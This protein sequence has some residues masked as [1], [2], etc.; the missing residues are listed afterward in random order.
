MSAIKNTSGQSLITKLLSMLF[1]IF[2]IGFA[3]QAAIHM[4]QTH[5]SEKL[6]REIQNAQIQGILGGEIISHIQEVEKSYYALT[7]QLKP[8]TR[9]LIT[10]EVEVHI[11]EINKLINVLEHGGVFTQQLQLNLPDKDNVINTWTYNPTKQ[12][13]Y[14]ILRIDVV[15]KLN[16]ILEQFDKTNALLD[17]AYDMLENN[18]ELFTQQ[19]EKI[20]HDIKRTNPLFIRLLENTNRIHYQQQ[21]YLKQLEE[22]VE[23]Q[24][25]GFKIVQYASIVFLLLLS[26]VLFKV[27]SR[28]IDKMTQ[29]LQVQKDKALAATE[30]KSQFLANMSH[31]I[32]TPLNAITG[33]INLLKQQESEPTKVKYLNTIDNSSQSLLGII[34]DIL[35]FSKIES[36]KLE[37]DLIDFDPHES[38]SSVADLFKAKCS[39]KNILLHVNIDKEMPQSLHSDPL[40]IKQV[41]SN[42]L[43]NAVKFSEEGKEITLDIKYNRAYQELSVVVVDQGIGISE[44]QQGKIFEA[45]SQAEANTTRQFGGTGLGLAICSLLVELL[46]GHLDVESELGVGS[47]FSFSLPIK[48]GQPINKASTTVKHT[49]EISGRVLLVEDNATNQLLMG[50]ILKK[51]QIQYDLAKDGLEAV[52]AFEERKYDLI[53]MDENMPNMSGSQATQKIRELEM[54][55]NLGHT[56]IVALTANAMKGDRERFIQA[57]MDDYLSKPLQIPELNRVIQE[58]L[59]S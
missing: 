29:A 30:S 8:K 58:Y 39:E 32:R 52:T 35:D 57:G 20:Q 9:A 21:N 40:R 24:K 10:K 47:R 56:P 27:I 43:S 7:N 17:V 50:A 3:L 11:D 34:N 25:F 28:H 42:L 46:G 38:F 14:D 45:F 48:E 54:E 31:E 41:I 22:D 33:F 12:Q 1:W 4:A 36:N 49:A 18:S 5:Y 15:P 6:D 23:E 13:A 44:E 2:L 19:L 55:S 26:L 59:S 37:F 51:M 53:L 16:A